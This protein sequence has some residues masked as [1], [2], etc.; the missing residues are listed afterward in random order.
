MAQGPLSNA[1][2]YIDYD[3]AALGNSATI[4]TWDN[5]NYTLSSLN[6]NHTIVADDST[7]D[8]SSGSVFSGVTMKAASGGLLF[9]L[10]QP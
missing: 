7:V 3:D 2:I 6:D 4:R 8:T 1:L 5:G 10:Q 9:L